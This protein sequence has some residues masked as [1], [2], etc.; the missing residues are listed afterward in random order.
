MK[1][2]ELKN[3]LDDALSGIREDPWLYRKVMNRAEQKKPER[4]RKI[5]YGA[6]IVIALLIVTM[7]AAIAAVSGWNVIRYLFD[8]SNRKV[9]DVEMTTVGKEAVTDSACLKVASATYDGR[10]LAFDW[11]MEN[12]K[13]EVPVYCRVKTFTGNGV[14]LWMDGCDDFEENWMPGAYMEN[15]AQ[16]GELIELPEEIVGADTIHVELKVSLFRPE[17]PVVHIPGY[18]SFDPALAAEKVAE[19]YYVIPDSDLPEGGGDGFIIYYEEEGW[20]HYFMP[21]ELPAGMGDYDVETL[22][23]SFDVPKNEVSVRQLETQELYENEHGTAYYTKAEI[24]SLGLYLALTT[25]AT[26]ETFLQEG[27][28]YLTDGA[29]NILVGWDKDMPRTEGWASG[30]KY[31][32]Y[33][34]YG[35]TEEELT[36]V[37]SL[38]WIPE[39]GEP[40]IFPVKVR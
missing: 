40:V 12:K 19:G 4:K 2:E 24:S 30:G 5:R 7:G 39:E 13:P 37:I 10:M 9:P 27:W 1:N 29:G 22:E 35:L 36:D 28:W 15:C 31:A 25:D 16:G 20:G 11:Y 17:R 21:D 33:H 14:R 34:W 8:G 6:V 32:N 26:D 3:R 18:N 38:S 23:L